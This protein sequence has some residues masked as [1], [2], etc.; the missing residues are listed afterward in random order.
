M[1]DGSVKDVR[2]FVHC[3]DTNLKAIHNQPQAQAIPSPLFVHCKD[4][5]LKAI[6]NSSLCWLDYCMLFV[7]C[8][9]TN[10]KAIHNKMQVI[11]L[12]KL[13]VR[14]LQRY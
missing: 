8:K 2:L 13:V 4:T 5:N 12:K 3:K 7:H 11:L 6:H 9:D 10:L 1:A 14:A